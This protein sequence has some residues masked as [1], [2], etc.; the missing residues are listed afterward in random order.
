MAHISNKITQI[1]D[2]INT[3]YK[4]IQGLEKEAK[5]YLKKSQESKGSAK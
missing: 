1:E 3:L 4:Q 5:E 2:K